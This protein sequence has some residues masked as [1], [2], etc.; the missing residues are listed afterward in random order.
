MGRSAPFRGRAEHAQ[1]AARQALVVVVG[2]VGRA[3]RGG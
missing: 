2:S 1:T 3:L